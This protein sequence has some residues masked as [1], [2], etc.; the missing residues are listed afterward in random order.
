MSG[1]PGTPGPLRWL[2]YAIGFRLPA[3][4]RDWVRHDLTDAGWRVRAGVRQLV[5]AVPVAIVCAEGGAPLEATA[6]LQSGPRARKSHLSVA[7]GNGRWLV[8]T[9]S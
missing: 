1:I 4:N 7:R 2:R 5:I 9:R 3:A 8:V 6:T